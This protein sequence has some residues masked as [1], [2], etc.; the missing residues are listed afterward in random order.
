MIFK[1][2]SLVLFLIAGM[3]SADVTVPEV[4][5]LRAP[6]V[7]FTFDDTHVNEW[8][9]AMPLL[10]K[11]GASATFFVTRFDQLSA[12]QLD[13]LRALREK[14]HAIGCHGLRHIKAAEHTKV[15]GIE[16]YLAREITPALVAMEKA[17]FQPTSFAYPSSNNDPVT[18]EALLKTFRHLRTGTGAREGQRY[19]QMDILFT[20]LGELASRGCLTGKGID[21]IGYPGNE[22]SLAQLLEAMDRAA[23]RGEVLT[24]YAHNIA[25]AS[26]S[27]HIRPATLEKILAHAQ[28]LGLHFYTFDDLP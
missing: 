17:G 6:G 24:L 12:E 16:D 11:Y 18:D 5:P 19:A 21:R 20:P 27:H 28:K 22:D 8:V 10:E 23:S 7:L 25:E 13:G 9:E 2:V 3:A 14:G 15:H 26:K 4:A 1:L